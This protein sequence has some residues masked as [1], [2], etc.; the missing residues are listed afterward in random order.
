MVHVA[1]HLPLNVR[2]MENC[3]AQNATHSDI[4]RTSSITCLAVLAD[5]A[6]NAAGAKRSNAPSVMDAAQ[7]TREPPCWTV[8][9]SCNKERT[10]QCDRGTLRVIT[11]GEPLAARELR[12]RLD[13]CTDQAAS[14]PTDHR[15]R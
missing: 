9:V 13:P 14:E 6:V 3:P 4:P 5:N 7:S 1:T 12:H 8:V 10:V 15:G 11:S 2:A